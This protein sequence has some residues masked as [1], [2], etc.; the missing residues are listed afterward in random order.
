MSSASLSEAASPAGAVRSKLRDLSGKTAVLGRENEE[1]R[2][3]VLPQGLRASCPPPFKATLTA[4]AT[5]APRMTVLNA[6][7]HSRGP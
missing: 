6:A 5:R 2:R 3:E 1:L 4:A 7:A